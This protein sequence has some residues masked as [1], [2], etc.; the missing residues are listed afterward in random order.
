[1]VRRARDC[2]RVVVL[3]SFPVPFS[4]PFSVWF[5]FMVT[6]SA[7]GPAPVPEAEHAGS[8]RGAVVVECTG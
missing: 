1:M 3:S 5:A 2:V 4:F 8:R 7:Q 6:V